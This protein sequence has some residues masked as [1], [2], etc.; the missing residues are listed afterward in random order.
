MAKYTNGLV[1]Q[2]VLD[3]VSDD[4]R[5]EGGDGQSRDVL[6]RAKLWFKRAKELSDNRSFYY[7][8]VLNNGLEGFLCSYE[9]N[10]GILDFWKGDVVEI[11]Y[12]NGEAKVGVVKTTSVAPTIYGGGYAIVVFPDGSE[13]THDWKSL[14]HS[15]IPQ[16]VLD[17]A[18]A[19][20][21]ASGK[22]PLSK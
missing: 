4:E 12:R 10:L 22:C 17:I 13:K 3:A 6:E 19:Q 14:T 15:K 7:D 16:S 21:M 20:I 11:R 9:S 2:M 5:R 1:A 8:A 18:K